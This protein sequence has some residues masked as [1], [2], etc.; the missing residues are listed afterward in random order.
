MNK[1]KFDLQLFHPL[2]ASTLL[3]P[4]LVDTSI[5]GQIM[6]DSQHIVIDFILKGDT[7]LIKHSPI[8]PTPQRKN[9]LWQST[10]F[11]VFTATTSHPYYS[12]YNI[13]PSHDWNVYTFKGYREGQSL[14][15]LI[16]SIKVKT[17]YS[18]EKLS[19]ITASLPL[20]PRLAGKE[21]AL[22]I[23]CVLQD[24]H[25]HLNYYALVHPNRKPD[26]HDKRSFVI[27]LNH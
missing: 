25:D 21:I 8:T 12:E 11:E 15:P 18:N 26:F 5:H 13:S 17:L 7:S 4:T 6:L 9:N 20:P 23:S 22:G 2:D 27:R 14:D 19:G 16:G 3:Q 24:I 10:C 1:C